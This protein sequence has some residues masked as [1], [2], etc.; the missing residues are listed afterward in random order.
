LVWTGFQVIDGG[1]RV[2]V[3]TSADVALDLVTTKDGLVATLRNCRIH[4]RNNSRTLDTRFFAT[5]VKQVSVRQR[6]KDVQLDIALKQPA[7]ATSHK[8][9]GPNGSQFW[10]IDFATA[11]PGRAAS[12]DGQAHAKSDPAAATVAAPATR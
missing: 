12:R 4:M 2:F 8:Q 6:R 7:P 1:S 9:T 10:V 5:P 11:A 3:Q